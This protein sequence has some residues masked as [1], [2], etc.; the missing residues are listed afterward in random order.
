MYN[1]NGPQMVN[2]RTEMVENDS[3]KECTMLMNIPLPTTLFNPLWLM[4]DYH[5]KTFVQYWD[6]ISTYPCLEKAGNWDLIPGKFCHLEG[7]FA[8]KMKKYIRNC[9]NSASFFFFF[10]LE[11]WT[12]FLGNLTFFPGCT[13]PIQIQ[14]WTYKFTHDLCS[15]LQ[16]F[17]IKKYIYTLER[18]RCREERKK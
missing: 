1:K 5:R 10:L 17:G 12:I 14:S 2:C 13:Y 9:W 7:N 4:K 11:T 15:F 8:L 3:L 16:T 18:I 6:S